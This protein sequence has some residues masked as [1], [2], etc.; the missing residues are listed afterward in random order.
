M[1]DL[2][3]KQ[4]SNTHYARIEPTPTK[5]AG[6][7]Q[8]AT[9]LADSF[10]QPIQPHPNVSQTEGGIFPMDP[11]SVSQTISAGELLIILGIEVFFH[12]LQ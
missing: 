4:A 12:E 11:P 9:E 8:P 7:C 3:Q 2:A 6:D 5:P 1:E 10:L